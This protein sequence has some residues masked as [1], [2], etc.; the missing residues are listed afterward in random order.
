MKNQTAELSA[1]IGPRGARLWRAALGAVVVLGLAARTEAADFTTT[2]TEGIGFDWNSA[3]W[4]PGQVTPSAGNTYETVFNGTPV[5]NNLSPTRLRNPAFAGVQTFTGDSLTLNT[6]TEIRMKQPGAILNFPG[7]NGNP[8]LILNGGTINAGDD[9][10]FPITGKVFVKA[11]S[12]IAM[13]DV[14]GGVVKPLRGVQL[15][16]QLSGSGTLVFYQQDNKDSG[17]VPQEISGNSNTYTG[18]IIVQAGWLLGSGTNSL[19]T[20]NITMDP[21]AP[22][23]VDPSVTLLTDPPQLEVNYDLVSPGQLTLMHGGMMILHQNCTFGVVN[24]E[25]TFLTPGTHTYAELSAAFPT[26]FTSG[27]S[28]SIKVVPPAKPFIAVQIPAPGGS[29]AADTIIDVEVRDGATTVNA[30]SVV[31]KLDGIVVAATVTQNNGQTSVKYTPPILLFPQTPHAVEIAYRDS[32]GSQADV[33]WSFTVAGALVDPAFRVVGAVD[34]TK[35]GFMARPYQV[36]NA[37]PPSIAFAEQELQGQQGPNLATTSGVDGNGFTPDTNGVYTITDVVNWDL[38][39]SGATLGDFTGATGQP[40]IFPPGFPG[41]GPNGFD[42]GAMEVLTY[43]KFPGQGT[44]TMGVNSDDGFKVTTGKAARDV[45]GTILGSFDG[46]RAAVDS[47]F[48]VVVPSAGIYPMRLLWFNGTG[49]WSVEWFTVLKDGTK[50]LINDPLSPIQAFRSAPSPVIV[51]AVTPGVGAAGVRPDTALN[52]TFL[53]GT[54]A[55]L[56]PAS[57][58]LS[59]NG[60]PTGT[61]I[62]RNGSVSTLDIPSAG[63]YPSGTNTMRLV[64]A[65]TSVPPLITTNVW[66]FVVPK[67]TLPLATVTLAVQEAAGNDWNTTGQWSD[68]KSATVS[69]AANPTNTYEM[70]PGSRLRSPNNGTDDTFPGGLLRV[71]GNGVLV[72]NPGSSAAVAEIRFKQVDFGVVRFP[73]LVLNGG[74]LD[75]GNDGT[76]VIGGKI[77]VA[78]DSNLYNDGTNDRGMQIDA[79]LTGAAALTWVEN[80]NFTYVSTYVHSLNITGTSNTFT[81]K[82]NVSTGPLLGTSPGS[83]GT[84][85]INVGLQGGLETLYDVNS[86]A[87]TLTLNGVMYLHQDD[88]FGSVI[89]NG[90]PLSVGKHTFADLSTAYPTNFPASW[91]SIIGSTASTGSGSIT[92]LSAPAA[93]PTITTAPQS[94]TVTAGASATFNVVAAGAAPLSYQWQF[95]GANILGATNAS[96]TVANAQ[97]ANAGAY[98]VVVSNAGGSVTSSPAATLTVNPAQTTPTVTLSIQQ[99]S[100]NDWN[101]VNQW[102]DGNPAKTSAAA[103]PATVYELL[104]GSRLRSPNNGTN[105][106]FPGATLKVDGNGAYVNSPG[107]TAPVAELRFKQ[108]DPGI[109]NFPNLILNG[110]QLDAGNNGTIILQ[111]KITVATN[112]TIYVDSGGS[113]RSFRI[114]SVLTGS[115]NLA[116]YNFGPV[117]T[118]SPTNVHS[119]NITGSANTFSGQWDAEVGALLGSGAGS[120]GTN[121]ITVGNQGVLET[122]YDVNNPNGS[123]I[124]N[125]NGQVYLHQND[126]FKSVIIGATALPAGTYTFAQLRASYPANF[127]ATWNAVAGS[128][129]SAS[130]GGITVLASASVT[131][132]I[133]QASGNDWNTAAQWSDG[134]PAKTSAAANPVTVYELLPGSRLRSPNNGTNDTFPGLFLK[135]D[136]NGAFVNG[137]TATAPV[138]ELRFKQLDPGIVNFPN[139]I[140]NG[141][142]LDAGNN[143][144]VILQGKIT[145]ATNSTIYVDSGGSLRTFKIDAQ[146]TGSGNLAWYNFGPVSTESPTNVHSLNITGTA[147]T[148]TGQWDAEVGVLLGSGAGSLGPNSITVGTNGVLETLYDVN[149]TNSSLTINGGGQIY[150]HQNDTFKSVII[151]GAGLTAGKYT[152]AQLAASYPANFPATW[153]AVVGSTNTTG[154]G[155]ITALT[156]AVLSFQGKFLPTVISGGNI[157]FSWSGGG[158]LQSAS[159]VTG[160][161]AD[162]SGAGSGPFSVPISAGGQKF[163]R[164][165]P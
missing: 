3:V 151:N 141:G 7:V 144:T 78:A 32:A 41:L 92:V 76:V 40:D 95:G 24:I 13:G 77:T 12:Y 31:L 29:P 156:T 100:G 131:L 109:V 38:N 27:G 43:L 55:Q 153:N 160:P 132:A 14:T 33:S 111:G 84:N 82:W 9:A 53:D 117:S 137:P 49:G 60:A 39:G 71:D 119:L 88:T 73:N 134:N 146:L 102:S 61:G 152:F 145:V 83:L 8:G 129:A 161:W 51:T 63:F 91:T 85:S 158:T 23:S 58:L 19:G 89:V 165:R 62:V 36:S 56:N 105:D 52:V 46:G 155:S 21:L 15:A 65:D 99:A 128:P 68:G 93:A 136:G 81:G 37:A 50:V 114:D 159:A 108:L 6:N 16:A 94:Q 69:A 135:V 98:T 42:N 70:L 118:E 28:G 107:A 112:S 10:I 130:S 57:V 67:Y 116:W 18:N 133:Q 120:L 164:L 126:T 26:N 66:S 104:P 59:V 30:S 113:L 150:L 96:L 90:T 147:N 101:T 115:G 97:A 79:Q 75:M 121:T 17:A 35:P 20:G 157:V 123:L 154:S 80:A 103:N 44:Y 110:G 127:P 149:N 74:Q 25:G 140:L 54:S 47:L 143:G 72:V 106:T 87:A 45:F 4:V 2:A 139:L 11:T 22:I 86:P 124:V 64:Y 163:Y 5:G 122:L 48:S 34:Q 1:L 125:G 142:Q 138:A 162:V 148:F